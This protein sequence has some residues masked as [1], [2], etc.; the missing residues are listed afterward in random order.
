MS[1][2]GRYNY[3]EVSAGRK[4]SSAWSGATARC[5]ALQLRLPDYCFSLASYSF[6]FETLRA[7]GGDRMK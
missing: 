4:S 7:A 6:N 5:D 3:G 1:T 2:A